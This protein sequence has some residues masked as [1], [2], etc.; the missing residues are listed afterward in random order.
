MTVGNCFFAGNESPE[1]NEG[2]QGML[3]NSKFLGQNLQK[4]R[5]QKEEDDSSNIQ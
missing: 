3:T 2:K 4:I 5:T 1:M